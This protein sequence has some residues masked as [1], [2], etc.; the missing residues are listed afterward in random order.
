MC[1]MDG[2]INMNIT[3]VAFIESADGTLVV[4]MQD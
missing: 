2:K 3:T 1:T 4:R